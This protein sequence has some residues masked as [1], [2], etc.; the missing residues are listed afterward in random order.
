MNDRHLSDDQLIDLCVSATGAGAEES[1]HL[2]VCPTCDT[3]RLSIVEILADLDAA[4]DVNTD[5]AFPPDKLE[6]QQA[7]I[8]QRVDQDG[9]PGRVITFPAYQ[10]PDTLLRSR[11]RVRWAAAAA[12]AAFVFG[13]FAGLFAHN[14]AGDTERPSAAVTVDRSQAPLRAVSTTFSEDEF[15]GQVEVAATQNGPVA[16]R[17]LDAMTPRAWDVSN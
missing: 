8:L 7:R 5:A 12:A 11:P 6:R 2:A 17:P 16:L 14:L 13:L 15:L 1:A 10:A 4:A 3:R 9:R